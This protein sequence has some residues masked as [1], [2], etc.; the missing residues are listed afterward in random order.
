MEI[1]EWLLCRGAAPFEEIN[2]F[3]DAHLGAYEAHHPRPVR[4]FHVE[5]TRSPDFVLDYLHYGRY[6][7]VK[8][9]RDRT[10]AFLNLA[11]NTANIDIPPDYSAPSLEVYR[12][13]AIQ[14][15]ESTKDLDVLIYVLH[16]EQ[17]LVTGTPSW[18][19]RWD[20]KNVDLFTEPW[21]TRKTSR[22]CEGFT[23]TLITRDT[24]GI[25]GV[26]F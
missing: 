14:H 5:H 18:V 8:D 23:P 4:M 20:I 24:L 2:G 10:Y 11:C 7:G 9:D 15:L 16:D 26:C 3:P 1:L 25:R 22:T 17:S 21:R 12:N 19:P 6:L 13:F